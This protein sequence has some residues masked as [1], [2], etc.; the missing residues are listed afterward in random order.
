MR[1]STRV[2]LRSHS[3]GQILWKKPID[4]NFL[5]DC[6]EKQTKNKKAQANYWANEVLTRGKKATWRFVILTAEEST[7]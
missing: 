7:R 5:P 4:H 1:N 3:N 2:K 6:W